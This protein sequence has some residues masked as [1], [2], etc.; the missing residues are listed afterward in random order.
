[1]TGRTGDNGIDGIDGIGLLR[2][3]EVLSF[4]VI[5]QCKRWRD[6]VGPST[7]R[8]FRGAMVGRT[9]KGMVIT[10]SYFTRDAI[11]EASRD[12]APAIDLIDGEQLVALLKKLRLGVA[13]ELVERVTVD[14]TWFDGI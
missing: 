13:T 1:M 6:P 11:R 9:D 5:F 3:Q 12:G 4:H 2:L 7:L 8:D 14:R 10:T